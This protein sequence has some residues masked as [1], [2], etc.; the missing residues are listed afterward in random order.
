MGVPDTDLGQP[1]RRMFLDAVAEVAPM[2]LV[3][4][5]ESVLP[6]FSQ[7]IAEDR[8]AHLQGGQLGQQ[9]ASPAGEAFDRELRRWGAQWHLTDD[10]ILLAAERTAGSWDGEA[11]L[12][13]P[14]R[15]GWLLGRDRYAWPESR[16]LMIEVDP[17]WEPGLEPRSEAASRLEDA[18]KAQLRDYLKRIEALALTRGFVPMKA[19]RRREEEGKKTKVHR[20]FRWL[21]QWQVLSMTRAEIADKEEVAVR[22]VAEAIA[23][24]SQEIG[25]TLRTQAG[26]ASD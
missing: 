14:P 23:T 12:K 4:L 22:S 7:A 20:H 21:A 24:R 1:A 25:L 15:P 8:R 2:V 17:G 10:W 16:K 19:S 13:I 26:N 3:R 18:V 5:R 6:L 9:E 11:R